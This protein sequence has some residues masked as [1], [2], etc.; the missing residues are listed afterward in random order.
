M[1]GGHALI[2]SAHW[3]AIEGVQ[4]A[5]PQNPAQIETKIENLSKKLKAE[6]KFDL[7]EQKAD[8][9]PL[10][11]HVITKELQLY[12][13]KITEALLSDSEV[14]RNTA[15]ESIREDQ[16]IQQ[17]LPYFIQFVMDQVSFNMRFLLLTM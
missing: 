16:G 7:L 5:I 10:V 12:Y 3:L 15:L 11:R 6:G 2:L 4:P 8:V 17:L 9:K 1:F 14:L 13:E